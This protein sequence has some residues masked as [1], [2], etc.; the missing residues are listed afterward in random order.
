LSDQTSERRDNSVLIALKELRG[1]EDERVKREQE[2]A[3]ARIEAERAAAEATVRRAREEEEARR[4]AE[5]DRVRRI[6]EEKQNRIREDQLRVEEAERRARVEAEMK[7][8]EERMRLE[9]QSRAHSR[10]PVKAVIGAVAVVALVGGILLYRLNAQHHE[11]QAAALRERQLVE[12]KANA[13]EAEFKAQLTQIK[14][15]MDE[16]MKAAK[17]EAERMKIR[18]DAEAKAREADVE[19][20]N[21]AAGGKSRNNRKIGDAPTPGTKAPKYKDPG[22]RDI[23][24]DIL[25]GL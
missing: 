15:E 3:R 12:E 25:N 13:R 7:L 5:E 21:G 24:D 23:N 8:Q 17:S 22:K 6:E 9:I 2:E 19:H 11:E 16:K 14:R 4:R 10:S 18:A 20:R 1:M